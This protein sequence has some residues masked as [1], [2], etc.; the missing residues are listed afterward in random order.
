[1][2]F[3]WDEAQDAHRQVYEQPHHEAKLSHELI[4]GGASFA[5]FKAFED[6][7]RKEGK[8][9]KHAFAKELLAGFVGAEV[10]KLAETKGMDEVDKLRAHHQAKQ[11][12]ERMYD[13]HYVQGHGADSYDPSRYPP[14]DRFGGPR[15]PGGPG[16][17]GGYGGPGGPGGFGG[18]GGPGGP[19]GFGGPGGP[20]GFGGPG[21][22]GGPGGFE[23]PPGGHHH[24]PREDRW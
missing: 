7:Q 17:P 12:A 2:G 8:E 20:G 23:G 16:G 4:A 11:S 13:E 18:P 19:G 3:G 22:P 5:A 14:P 1:M 21:G 9:V 24:H 15:G 10:D 6:H